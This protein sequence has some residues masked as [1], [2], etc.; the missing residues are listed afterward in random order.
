MNFEINKTHLFGDICKSIET[1]GWVDIENEYYNFL[2][3][4]IKGSEYKDPAI[5]NEELDFI[6]DKLI[7][8]L[9]YI[10]KKEEDSHIYDSDFDI[11]ITGPINKQEVSIKAIEYYNNLN[12][13]NL[14]NEDEYYN[15]KKIIEQKPI[16][17][18][19][20][21]LLI[22]NYTKTADLYRSDNFKVNHI[23]GNLENPNSVIF[24]YGDELDLNYKELSR[25][26]D[27]EYLRNIKS[28]KYLES[29]NYRDVLSFIESDQYQIYIMGHSCGNSDRTLL[30]TL[31]EHNN[32]VSIKPFYYKS[33]NGKDNYLDIIQNISRNFTDMKLM[34][35][36]VVNKTY[37]EPLPQKRRNKRPTI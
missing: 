31:F 8:Y 30:N 11:K 25:L 13:Q 24:G 32:C 15:A 33:P 19:S 37:C 17:P 23:H 36:R 22:F 29:S 34:R 5:L 21:M 12:E 9:T 28:I 27:N 26:N 6:K 4:S 16:K 7:E 20:I 3:P 10:E 35:D 18:K 14:R 1:K 2:L